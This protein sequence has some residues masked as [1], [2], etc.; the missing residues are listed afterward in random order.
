MG[1]I[2]I[3][4]CYG[5]GKNTILDKLSEK[6]KIP[7]FSAGMLI[8]E[9]ND[10]FYGRNKYVTDKKNNQ[11]LLIG[12][13]EK[14]LKKFPRFFLDGHFCIFKKGNIPD[15][16]PLEDLAQMHF[17]KIFLLETE[18]SKIL[19]NLKSRDDKKYSLDNIE[20][21]MTTENRQ[22]HTFSEKTH[23]PLYIHHMLFD[24]TD[25]LQILSN[26]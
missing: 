2:F 13:I 15:P 9:V 10:E 19:K 17:E 14:K 8:S 4:G 7:H 5:V 26:I 16:L 20:A 25:V 22:A 3:A 18:S 11:I 23:I 21:L 6:T 1:V 12:Q 24:D